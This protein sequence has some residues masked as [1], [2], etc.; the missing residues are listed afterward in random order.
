[1]ATQPP[2]FIEMTDPLKANHWLHVTESKFEL[3]HY[4]EF[5]KTLFVSWFMT[6]FESGVLMDV[7]NNG[8]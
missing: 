2:E 1:M 5:Q 6:R 4:S 8:T 7:E 3:L